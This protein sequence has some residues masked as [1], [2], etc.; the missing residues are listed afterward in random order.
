MKNLKTK[1][2]TIVITFVLMLTFAATLVTL[3]LVSARDPPWQTPT[4]A[5]MSAAPNPIGVGQQVLRHPLRAQDRRPA[6][7]RHGQY[8]LVRQVRVEGR[9]AAQMLEQALGCLLRHAL[10]GL[11]PL[12]ERG[13]ASDGALER[14]PQKDHR[15][16][17]LGWRVYD[18]HAGIHSVGAQRLEC[19]A[20]LPDADML[21]QVAAGGYASHWGVAF[22]PDRG[23]RCGAGG[24]RSPLRVTL[25][26]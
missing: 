26:R 4:W 14:T 5:Y 8:K 22:Q 21:G 7:Q 18:V 10:G 3:P 11:A 20:F 17:S 13:E 6:S 24:S 19:R 9:I 16:L 2:K 12:S 23:S 25:F 1:S 15:P